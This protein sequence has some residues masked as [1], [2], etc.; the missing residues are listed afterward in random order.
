MTLGWCSAGE[1]CIAGTKNGKKPPKI[2][3]FK[4]LSNRPKYPLSNFNNS[5][6]TQIIPIMLSK[7]RILTTLMTL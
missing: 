6:S 5:N 7:L 3:P 1:G 4:L 2:K